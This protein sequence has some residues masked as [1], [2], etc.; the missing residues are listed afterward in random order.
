MLSVSS[1]TGAI[2]CRGDIHI[3]VNQADGAGCGGWIEIDERIPYILLGVG[4]VSK[5]VSVSTLEEIT[6]GSPIPLRHSGWLGSIIFIDAAQIVWMVGCR[7]W[8][9]QRNCDGSHEAT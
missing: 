3:S 5:L 2:W 8:T 9:P 1:G 4:C 6:D 7:D